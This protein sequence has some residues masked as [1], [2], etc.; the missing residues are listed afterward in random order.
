MLPI[1]LCY[2]TVYKL[3]GPRCCIDPSPSLILS[4][5]Q[6]SFEAY[7]NVVTA[8]CVLVFT[9]CS[10]FLTVNDRLVPFSSLNMTKRRR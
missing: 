5:V 1:T 10:D 6:Y 4:L 8:T 7:L 3:S 2:T 9:R